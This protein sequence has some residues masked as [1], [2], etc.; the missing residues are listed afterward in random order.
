MKWQKAR[1]IY[2]DRWLVIEAL[3]THIEEDRRLKL[4]EV[5][6]LDTCDDGVTI[7]RLYRT[8]RQ[9]L[10]GREILFVHSANTEPDIRDLT[11]QGRFYHVPRATPRVE[12]V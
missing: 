1:A 5:A 11:D 10:R 3:E 6:V 7:M 2:P 4:D 9:K 8:W 12:R